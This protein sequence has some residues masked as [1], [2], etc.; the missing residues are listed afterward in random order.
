MKSAGSSVHPD[1]AEFVAVV[2]DLLQRR[3]NEAGHLAPR[4]WLHDEWGPRTWTR[5]EFEYTVYHSY[6]PMRQGRVTRPPRREVVMQI[7]DYLNCSLEERN[8]LLLAARATPI[9]PYLTGEKLDEALEAARRV[10][11]TLPLPAIIINR[12]WHIH[13]IN[14]HVLTLNG[15]QPEALKKIPP[16]KFNIIQLLFDP[17]LPLQP[18]LIENR[19]SWTRMVR[20]TIYGFKMANLICQYEPWYQALLSQLMQ[21]PEFEHH[22]QTVR[23]DAEFGSDISTHSQPISAIVE[24]SV[25]HTQRS[26]KKARLRPLLI[27]VGYFQFDF[28]QIVAFLPVDEESRLVLRDIGIPAP[29]EFSTL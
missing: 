28:P 25:L 11:Q 1:C 10:V 7:A 24:V 26:S 13:H 23:V 20:Q 9:A 17:A 27:S 8:R 14:A 15:A 22:W 18:H 16:H 12:D 21:L 29:D 2:E 5:T 4:S 6:K 3:Q 19:P